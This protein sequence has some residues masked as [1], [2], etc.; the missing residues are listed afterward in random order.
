MKKGKYTHVQALLA[1]GNTRREAAEYYNFRDKQV[2][3]GLL[4]RERRK[5]RR[6]AAGIPPRS[7]G[8]LRKYAA[9]RDIVSE[10]AYKIQR[11]RMENKPAG[12]SAL[13]RKGVMAKVKYH[14]IYRHR[15]EYPEA[16]AAPF[17]PPARQ[18]R[19][20]R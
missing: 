5:G 17:P 12:F 4:K 3:K 9:P 15:M 16:A 13:H 14:V 18:V 19:S 20:R 6:L 7:R 2:I 8:R 11:L 10:Q 1:E